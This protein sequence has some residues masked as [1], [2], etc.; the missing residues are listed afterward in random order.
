TTDPE[1]NRGIP[2]ASR[3]AILAQV[4]EDYQ[5]ALDQIPAAPANAGFAGVN[6]VR[7]ALARYHLYAGDWSLA[8]QYATEVINSGKYTLAPQY[9]DLITKDFTSEAIFEMGY[10]LSD[11]PGTGSVGLN[12]LFVGR[13]EIIPSNQAVIALNA[14]EAGDRK[15]SVTFNPVNLKGSDNGWTV[16]KYGTADEDNNN[17]VLFRLGEMYLI[18]AEARARQNRVTGASSAVEDLNV[19]RRR[20][21]AP[22]TNEGVVGQAAVLLEIERER[23]YELAFEGHRWYDLVRTERIDPV[24]TAFSPNWKSTYEQ[25]PIPLN[26]IQNNPALAND[27][28][29]G[30]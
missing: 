19:L 12:N 18:R 5:F 15:N 24:M 2:R 13:R 10:T 16:R 1:T 27:Q 29:P 11:D 25:L 4:R 20:A 14:T 3:E 8:E 22:L 9:A 21:K 17:I 7:A 30:Y 23:L 26:E 6:T 28:N